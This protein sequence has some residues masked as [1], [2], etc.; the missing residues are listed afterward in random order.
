MKKFLQLLAALTT[1]T[2]AIGVLLLAAALAV[3][4]VTR[5]AGA[6]SLGFLTE[7]TRE[8]GVSGGILWQITGTLI[9]FITA[10]L[11][12]LPF[13]TALGITRAWLLAP[14]GRAARS[15]GFFLHLLNAVPS[16][17]LGILGLILFTRLMDWGKS[18]LAGGILLGIMI[19]PTAAVMLAHRIGSLP[20]GQLDAAAVLGLHRG[21]IIRAVILPQ[22]AAALLSGMLLGL[23]RAAGET[24]PIL[25]VAAVFS[26]ATIPTG[27]R[28][29][30]VLALPYH[31]FVL[32]QDS[33][34]DA[35]RA[36]LWGAALVLV[37]LV[38]LPA[39]LAI[40][41]R[42]KLHNAADHA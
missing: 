40:P 5:G 22:S 9:L 7:E 6:I 42:R 25:F 38:S 37:A 19:V 18:W 35:S 14:G 33:F 34:Q 12:A 36:N 20:R 11:V 8:A 24:A 27:I 3:V 21:H 4:L 17:L 41:L 29:Q 32:A 2:A 16:I 1:G 23:A 10:A 30:P 31:I 13:A 28:E 26:G 15:L 39:L